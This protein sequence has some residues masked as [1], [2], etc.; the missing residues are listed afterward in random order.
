MS[1]DWAAEHRRDA[2]AFLLAALDGDD[3][4]A[5]LVAEAN[6]SG[7]VSTLASMVCQQLDAQGIDPRQWAREQQ[8]QEIAGLL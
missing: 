5:Q 4:G 3:K 2:L 1:E 7:V 8:A 6:I